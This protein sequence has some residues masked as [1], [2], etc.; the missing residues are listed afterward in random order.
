MAW[1]QGQ[2]S[3]IK[4]SISASRTI[5]VA[6]IRGLGSKQ[7]QR[8]RKEFRD[9]DKARLRVSKNSLISISMKESGMA[10]ADLADFVDD[11]TALVFTDLDAFDLYKVMEEGKIPAPIKAGA[12]APHDIVVEQGQTSLKPGPIVGEL[13]NLGIPAGISGGKVEIKQRKVAVKE[14]EKVSAPL[15]EML[16]KLEIYPVTE[17]LDLRAV[18]DAESE[19]VFTHDVLHIDPS[20]Y[21]ADIK[22]GIMSALALSTHIKYEYPTSY[23]IGDLINEASIKSQALALDIAYPTSLTIKPLIRMAYSDARNLSINACIYEPDTIEHLLAKARSQAQGLAVA[24]R[25]RE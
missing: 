7:L 1:K 22:E 2:V 5:G 6:K 16:S 23:T 13:Q 4:D 21:F 25:L 11:Q 24:A 9:T 15:A 3:S 10:M 12:V 19:T 14:G 18:Y 20:K 8:I 17:G